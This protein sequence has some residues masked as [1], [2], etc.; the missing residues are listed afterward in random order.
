[1]KNLMMKTGITKIDPRIIYF[2]LML[3]AL[4]AGAGAPIGPDGFSM[5]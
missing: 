3:G 5:P 4:A 1:M 2:L